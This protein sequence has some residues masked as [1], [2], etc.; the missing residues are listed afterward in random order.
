MKICALGVLSGVFLLQACGGPVYHQP[1]V[2]HQ[3]IHPL[4]VQKNSSQNTSNNSIKT[5]ITIN[6]T[7]YTLPKPCSMARSFGGD[8]DSRQF[9]DDSDSRQFGEDAD[10]RQF[11]DDADSRQFGDDADSRQFGDDAD[12][13][14]FGDLADSRQ[15]GEDADSRQFGDDADSRQFGDLADSRQ[16]GD[17]AESRQFGDDADSRQFGDDADSRQFGNLSNQF[18]CIKVPSMNSVVVTGLVG[19]EVVNVVTGD[20]FLNYKRVNNNIVLKY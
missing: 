2:S 13:R 20:E 10:S 18:K 3:G 14:Q 17:D 11:G 1:K 8:A 16:F 7:D 6:G 19:H 5:V 4:V 9:G 15:F 12:S